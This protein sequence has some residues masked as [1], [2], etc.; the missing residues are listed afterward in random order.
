M[1]NVRAKKSLGQHFLID[2]GIAKRIAGS[3][4][5][6]RNYDCLL[7]IGPGTGALTQHLAG[8]NKE[9]LLVELD[10]DSIRHLEQHFPSMK[11][12][13]VEADFLEMDLESLFNNRPFGIIGNFPYHISSQILFRVFYDRDL[14]PE[15]VG[16]FQKEVAVRI[17]APPGGRDYGILSVLMQA[18][19]DIEYLF[20]VDSSSF[21]PPPKV[22]SGVL[23]LKRNN[24]ASLPCDE[25]MFV[26][27]VRAGFNQRRKMLRNA[28]KAF[29]PNPF[30][31]RG[32]LEKRAERLAWQD[33]AFLAGV[34]TGMETSS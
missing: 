34:A 28:L 4:A 32:L 14:V 13:I 10:K 11:E 9:L 6:H 27:I 2:A 33:F 18:F 3:L 8:L 24:N 30:D 15:L 19:Y 17:A 20:T 5:F 22:L 26:R 1:G 16:M 31:D 7:E 12:K 21:R 29:F 25:A 23:R